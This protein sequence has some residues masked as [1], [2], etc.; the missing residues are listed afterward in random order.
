MKVFIGDILYID[1]TWLHSNNRTKVGSTAVH[2]K[3][4]LVM[5]IA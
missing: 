4:L 3:I 5:N 2:G 1:M